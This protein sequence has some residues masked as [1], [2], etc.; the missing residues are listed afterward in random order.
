MTDS[1][2][3][4]AACGHAIDASARTCPYCGAD[5]ETGEKLD[6]RSVVETHF[7]PRG[8]LTTAQRIGRAIREQQAL[9]VG[10]LILVVFLLVGAAHQ[11][12]VRRSATGD[13]SAPAVP[14]T[15]LADLND[16]SQTERAPLPE[17]DFSWTGRPETMEVFLIEPGAV[18]PPAAAEAA[19]G[20]APRTASAVPRPAP[21]PPRQTPAPGPR[22]SPPADP[23]P[24]TNEPVTPS[25]DPQQQQDAPPPDAADPPPAP[26]DPPP[27]RF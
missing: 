23:G 6:T 24:Q 27:P 1:K 10:I 12:A 25:S 4:C 26:A 16:A 2:R 20:S 13:R 14:L 21:R 15:D 19:S 17:L 9:A 8:E 11:M 22:T 7:P 18:P 3:D 5:P